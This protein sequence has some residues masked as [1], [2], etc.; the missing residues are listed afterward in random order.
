MEGLPARLDDLIAYVQSQDPSGGPLDHLSD[1]VLVAERL[2][3]L[4]DHLIGHFV[5]QARKAGASWTEI[6]QSM[7]VTKQ[8][9]QK[10]FVPRSSDMPP[11]GA[12][13]L[14]ARFT[15]RARRAVAAAQNEAL[16][17]KHAEVTTAHVILGLLTEPEGLAARAIQAQGISLDAVRTAIVESLGP[18]A[19]R[20]ASGHVPFS[21]NAK[22]ALDLTLRE[23]LRLGHNYVGTEHILLGIRTDETSPGAQ[24]LIALGVDKD[25]AEEWIILELRKIQ[26]HKRGDR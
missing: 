6:G 1:A 9:A 19:E 22:K 5:D 3:E 25:R 20:P 18:P 15:D 26:E 23:A 21:A 24:T 2:G 13:G 16:G 10:R 8:A 17:A 14:H 7:G 12:T 4:A 11:L